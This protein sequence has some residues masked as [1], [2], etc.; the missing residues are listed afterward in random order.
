MQILLTADVLDIDGSISGTG[1]HATSGP[2]R[3]IRPS[4]PLRLPHFGGEEGRL[5]PA[6]AVGYTTGRK[7]G[8]AGGSP[9]PRFHR[10]VVAGLRSNPAGQRGADYDRS[11]LGGSGRRPMRSHRGAAAA[12]TSITPTL[13]IDWVDAGANSIKNVLASMAQAAL[14]PTR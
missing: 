14:Q 10:P 11:G 2:Q 5:V 8:I 6:G 9:G 4:P 1:H 3:S 12:A 7:S 13:A